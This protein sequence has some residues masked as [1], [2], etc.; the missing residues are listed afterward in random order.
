[1]DDPRYDGRLYG[2]LAAVTEESRVG[3]VLARMVRT[4]DW[5]GRLLNGSDYPL[6]GYMPAFSLRRLAD[7]GFLDADQAQVLREIR[8]YNPLLFD[9]V[10]KRHI[11]VD[12]ERL[13]PA[14]F[15]TAR[16]LRRSS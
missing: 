14:A 13:P 11:A 2:D 16:S 8:R 12:G 3:P 4:K 9:F 15:E 6:P 10:L 7:A 1:M 5:H